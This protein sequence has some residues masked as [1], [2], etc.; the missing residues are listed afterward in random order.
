MSPFKWL[1][2]FAAAAALAS[3]THAGPLTF[4]GA[5]DRALAGSPSLRATQF[6]VEAAL[7][8]SRA[9]GALPDPKL[10]LGVEG[11]PVSGPFAGR[12]G[13][14]DFA[15]A[16]IGF[17]QD[18]PN[19]ARR[20][21]SVAGAGAAISEAE[22]KRQ[23]EVRRVKVA[24]ALAWVDVAY[25]ERRLVALDQ[26]LASLTP[27]W[28]A[29]PS[30]VAA[31]RSRPAQALAPIQMRAALEDRRSEVTASLARDRAEL[32]RRTGEPAP[33]AA[34]APPH[35]EIDPAALRSALETNPT[36]LAYASA[37]TRAETD[38]EAA[39]AAKRPDWGWQVAYARRDPRFGNLVSAGVTL[40]LPLFAG[41]RQE[42][43]LA[44]R[45]A[46]AS[47]AYAE[48]EDA[49]RELAAQLEA[50]LADHDMHHE[51]WMRTLTVVL[52]AAQHRAHLETAS[53][54]AGTADL[55]DVLDAMSALADARLTAL[56]R[57][58]MVM[59]D[60]ARIVLT[61]GADQ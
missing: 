2:V 29:Q 60:G 14:E 39:R 11:F 28:E 9:A 45:K 18:V 34:G 16:R 40:S 47:R 55:A 54:A 17:M 13:Q 46:D 19:R 4:Q 41:A 51:Q 32:T 36:V 12:P 6:Q 35:Y 23:V 27:L 21:A 30:A 22:A 25:A 48:R 7:A 38:V 42:P 3:P 56:E 33:S 59:L 24:T 15:A 8:A 52:P 57:E 10:S 43:L 53:Y 44:A 1:P 20:R 31:G 50:D 49:R 5:I 61:Y 26:V 37:A 58:A